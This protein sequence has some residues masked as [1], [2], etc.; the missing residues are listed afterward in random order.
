[1]DLL[2]VLPQGVEPE[3][4]AEVAAKAVVALLEDEGSN[5]EENIE[6]AIELGRMVISILDTYPEIDP[7]RASRA[8]IDESKHG[9]WDPSARR[10]SLESRSEPHPTNGRDRTGL[11]SRRPRQLGD[12]SD[13]PCESLT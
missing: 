10:S 7:P 13:Q 1:M 6:L 5:R 8:G 2:D 11:A 3:L 9:I 4:Q 12:G